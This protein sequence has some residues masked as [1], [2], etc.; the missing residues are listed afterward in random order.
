MTTQSLH[1]INR[2][3]QPQANNQRSKDNPA[4]QQPVKLCQQEETELLSVTTS[5]LAGIEES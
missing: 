1:S 4:L 5:M 3:Q 2:S